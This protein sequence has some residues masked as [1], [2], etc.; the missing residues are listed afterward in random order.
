MSTSRRLLLDASPDFVPPVVEDW[1]PEPPPS[2]SQLLIDTLRERATEPGEFLRSFRSLLRGPRHAFERAVELSRSMGT[3][4][5]RDSFAPRTSINARTGRHRLLSV[6]RVPL[7]DVK[8][9]RKALGGTVNDVLLAGVGGG[10]NRLLT[11]RG[12]DVE[13]LRLRVLIPVSVRADDQH[14]AL[15]NKISAMFVSLP[16]HDAHPVE[17]LDA[18]SEQTADLKEKRQALSAGLI[19]NVGDYAPPTLMS[20]AGRVMHRQPFVN[21]VVT[22]VPGPQMPLY[23]MGARLLEAFPIVPLTRNT[24]D[25]RRD[26]FLRRHAALRIVGRP[27]RGERSRSARRRDRGRVRGDGQSRE[28]VGGD[29]V[30]EFWERDAWELADD[31]RAGKLQSV[32]LLD[33]FLARVEKFNEELNA[34][35]FLDVEGARRR[36]ADVDAAVARGEDPGMW[37]GVPMGVKEL[38]AVEG[39]PDTHASMLFKDDI[40]DHTATEPERLRDA[41]AVLV[42]L[43]TSP[44]FGS[45]NWTRTYLH[46]VTRNPWN[47]ERTPGGSSGGSAAAVAVGMM[48]ICTGSDGGGSIR[49]PSAYSG[50]FGFKVSFGRVG[51]A[52]AY[53]TGLTSVPGP[54]CR[55]VRDAAR[56]VDAIAGPTDI[57]PTSL[58]KPARSYEDAVTSGA[59]VARLRGLRA[60]WSSTLG[61]AVCDPEVEKLA[62]EAAL[63]LCEDAGIELVDVDFH[64]PRPGMAWSVI[65]DIDDSSHY[66]E[67]A[68]GRF[69]EVTPVSRSGFEYMENVRIDQVMRAMQRRWEI[70]RAI[71]DVFDEADLILTPTTATTALDAKGSRRARSRANP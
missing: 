29:P 21:L 59:A 42:G 8:I 62:H 65:S 54:M 34:F 47:P 44:E 6:V 37:A 22:N 46:G 41:G 30:T 56:Y 40:A 14:G 12:D 63:A 15:G 49:I 1:T 66:L 35:C 68:R 70:L 10:L 50:L 31:V 20:L 17:R 4:V 57:D 18:I 32:D 45:T 52:G 55:S 33:S 69:A 61:F 67:A 38:A 27:G 24:H 26:S 36:A 71:A 3:M 51:S 9:I 43:T 64:L 16:V 60:A 53:D 11:S 25:R 23:L 7:A 28:R 58:P 48:P 19:L 5:N 2:P 39:W 13:G